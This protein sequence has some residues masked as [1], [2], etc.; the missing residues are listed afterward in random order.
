MTH[1]KRKILLKK[2][3]YNIVVGEKI[4]TVDLSYRNLIF[5]VALKLKSTK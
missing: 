4:N 1:R 2:E 5:P 3:I